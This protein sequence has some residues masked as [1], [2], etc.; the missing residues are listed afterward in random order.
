M[1]FVSKKIFFLF[2]GLSL[3]VLIT[4]GAAH[5]EPADKDDLAVTLLYS[6]AR[7]EKPEE[8]AAFFKQTADECAGTPFAPEALWRLSQ[9]YVDGF[10][11]PDIKNAAKALER[12]CSEYPQSEWLFNVQMTLLGYYENLKDWKNYT[13]LS[14]KILE[15]KSVPQNLRDDIA[16]KHTEAKKK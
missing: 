4:C 1:N 15:N 13:A 8:K 9:L 12:F 6:A 10:D 3:A 16:R 14:G 11:E 5:A 7:A 2:V